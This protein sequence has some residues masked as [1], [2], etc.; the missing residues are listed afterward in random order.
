LNCFRF[1]GF[2]RR[3]EVDSLTLDEYEQLIQAYELKT[4]DK[5]Y[6]VHVQ[7]FL[8]R[9]VKAE[10]RV[11]KSKSRPVYDKFEKFFDY[12]KEVDNV[13]NKKQKGIKPKFSGLGEIL[14][15]GGKDE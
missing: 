2:K 11:S 10:K 3:S 12:K 8:N 7:A 1:L 15:R 5:M 6:F 13:L 14:R 4:V 9:N